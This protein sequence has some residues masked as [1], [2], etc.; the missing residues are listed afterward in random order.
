MSYKVT[1]PLELCKTSPSTSNR[2]QLFWVCN[3]SHSC[4]PTDLSALWQQ[5][6]GFTATNTSTFYLLPLADLVNICVLVVESLETSPKVISKRGGSAMSIVGATL[7]EIVGFP[8]SAPN[9]WKSNFD[10]LD[11]IRNHN[12]LIVMLYYHGVA[13]CSYCSHD[14]EKCNAMLVQPLRYT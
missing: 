8:I 9:I 3:C 14:A 6:R 1:I 7:V 11:R 13:A 10:N 5:Q 4:L 12:R 2:Q